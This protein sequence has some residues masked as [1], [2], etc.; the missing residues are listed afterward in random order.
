[1]K[2]L[3]GELHESLAPFQGRAFYVYHGAFAYFAQ[4]YGLEQKVIQIA[5]RN[6]TPKQI[7]SIAKQAKAEGVK[8]IFVQPQ[9]DESSALSLAETIGGKVKTLDPLEKDVLSN[10]RTIAA[11]IVAGH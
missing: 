8:T 3:D 10:L 2:T 6:P 5:G 7:T 4:N 11:T 9:F 1:V